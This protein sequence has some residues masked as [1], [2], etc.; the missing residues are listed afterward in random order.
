MYIVIKATARYSVPQN[1]NKPVRQVMA[2]P[3]RAVLLTKASIRLHLN[4]SVP[5]QLRILQALVW[6]GCPKHGFPPFCGT[7]FVQV[8]TRRWKRPLPHV[9]E[10]GPNPLHGLYP[11]STVGTTGIITVTHFW[12]QAELHVKC[13]EVKTAEV[14]FWTISSLVWVVKDWYERTCCAC[15]KSFLFLSNLSA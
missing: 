11:P 12:R 10:Q 7:G 4:L 3:G 14:L 15:I 1:R 13:D 2:G 6:T 5:G 8:R 9:F